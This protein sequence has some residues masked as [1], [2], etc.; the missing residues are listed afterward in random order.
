[1]TVSARDIHDVERRTFTGE[2]SL[3]TNAP[4]NFPFDGDDE[5]VELLALAGCALAR[6]AAASLSF[7]CAFCC[8]LTRAR[9]SSTLAPSL[10]AEFHEIDSI[11]GHL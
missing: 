11:S 3:R 1:M 8:S 5:G 9:S 7:A 4:G 6:D 2:L 10:T